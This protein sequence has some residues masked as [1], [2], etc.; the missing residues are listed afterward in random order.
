MY[1]LKSQQ[2][3]QFHYKLYRIL[4]KLTIFNRRINNNA[5]KVKMNSRKLVILFMYILLGLCNVTQSKMA[6]LQSLL[7]TSVLPFLSFI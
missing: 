5:N 7:Q 2:N 3:P 4:S 1:I 6:A